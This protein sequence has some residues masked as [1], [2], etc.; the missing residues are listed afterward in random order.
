MYFPPAGGGG[1][2]R[3]LKLAQYLPALGHRDARARA[4]RP[5]VGAPRPRP[6]RPDAGVGAPRALPRP[7]G[8]PARGGAA[9]GRGRARARGVAGARH[10]AAPP[11][12]GRERELQ[13]DR[14]PRRDRHRAARG[15]RRRLT[16][17]PPGSVHLVGAAVQRATGARWVADLRDPLVANQHRRADTAATRARQATNERLARLVARRADAISCVSEAIARGDARARAARARAHDRE[18]LRL[19]RLRRARVH[20]RPRFRI[21]HAGSFFGKRDPRPF[22][23][24]LR[25]SRHRRRRALRRRLPRVRPR[26]GRVPRARRP[27]RADPVRAPRGVAPPP[28]RL[29]GAAPARAGRGRAREGRALREGLRVPRRRA[30]RSSPSF[31]R[32]ARRRTSSARRAPGSSSRPTTSTAS[33][34]R[35][36]S[37]TRGHLNGGAARG[38]APRRR[39]RAPLAPGAG[40]GDGRAAAGGR[41]VTTHALPLARRVA[42]AR[43]R[44]AGARRALP[45][46]GADGHVPQAPVGAR[47]LADALGRPHVGL[48][49]PLRVG[50]AG[51]RGRA[52]DA[53]RAS[54]RSPSSLAFALV[55]L[56]GFYNLDTGQALAQ[57]SKGMVKYVLHFGF[58]VT[59]VALLARRSLAFYWLALAAFCGGIAVNALYG[60][61]QLAL[62]EVTGTNLDS[63]LIEPITS[64][65]SGHQRLRRGRRDAGG[66]PAERADR[67]PEPPRDRA[68]R[69][70]CSC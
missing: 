60:V 57:W 70:R 9:R 7:A 40:R 18:R 1:V 20:A 62:A 56:A 4:R 5:E 50:P 36:A 6:P 39:P 34:T 14:D 10:R 12:P 59:G 61:V 68:R 28:A 15:H 47:R 24:A 54:S 69:S 55:Y 21:T 45:R 51:A 2:Q 48:P 17:S 26:V 46:D 22:L 3:P 37:S 52:P 29:R 66:L 44:P 49:R 38:R 58:L 35:S 8:A 53:H 67:R 32:T 27:A 63:L 42:R 13:P 65:Q 31:L 16:T 43:R 23:Q 25:D 11:A 64:R 19:R 30:A 41:G 33:A